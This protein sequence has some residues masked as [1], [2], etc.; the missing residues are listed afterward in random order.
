MRTAAATTGQPFAKPQASVSADSAA[1]PRSRSSAVS[2]LAPLYKKVPVIGDQLTVLGQ[3]FDLN[4]G[5]KEGISSPVPPQDPGP[6]SPPGPADKKSLPAAMHDAAA[7]KI[8]KST[9][10]KDQSAKDRAFLLWRGF[11]SSLPDA[12]ETDDAFLSDYENPLS[13]AKTLVILFGQHLHDQDLRGKEQAWT[14]HKIKAT[15]SKVASN[16]CREG[17]RRGVP[18]AATDAFSDKTVIKGLNVQKRSGAEA[19][20]AARAQKTIANMAYDPLW[21]PEDRQLLWDENGFTTKDGMR[22]NVT[23]TAMAT[24][25]HV[26]RRASSLFAPEGVFVGGKE[27]V[28]AAKAAKSPAPEREGDHMLRLMDTK[29][30]VRMVNDQGQPEYV[31]CDCDDLRMTMGFDNKIIVTRDDIRGRNSVSRYSLGFLTSKIT[32]GGGTF[33]AKDEVMLDRS[34]PASTMLVEDL[35][36]CILN[37][38]PPKSKRVAPDNEGLFSR[39]NPITGAHTAPRKKDVV[40]MMKM[41]GETHLIPAECITIKSFRSGLVTEHERAGIDP[42]I[43]RAS[44]GWAPGSTVPATIYS[45]NKTLGV[46]G[47]Q[48][49]L[50]IHPAAQAAARP[51]KKRVQETP[52]P[53]EPTS[54]S[55]FMTLRPK[56]K[57]A[58]SR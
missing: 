33:R 13:T 6:S 57:C 43:T 2:T 19:R 29:A 46:L 15:V 24:G 7:T 36:L 23:Y 9:G 1:W 45:R 39:Y 12:C 42:A 40:S 41:R 47:L 55:G 38:R 3:S 48:P 27:A 22:G 56:V 53:D 25:V 44:G 5:P 11:I 10:S 58:R 35:T 32:S 34:T 14:L 26:G 17:I 30:V 21:L 4:Q 52:L 51:T 37:S 31:P 16:F 54:Q 18:L 50:P 20:A 28:A 8:K 49:R